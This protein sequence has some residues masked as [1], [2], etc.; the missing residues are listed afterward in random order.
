MLLVCFIWLKYSLVANQTNVTMHCL[1]YQYNIISMC[2]FDVPSLLFTRM[3][4]CLFVQRKTNEY[5][6]I[7]IYNNVRFCFC[8]YSEI[9]CLIHLE[10]IITADP[11]FILHYCVNL[12]NYHSLRNLSVTTMPIL[13]VHFRWDT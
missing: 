11:N 3:Q 7:K 8:F 1:S 9:V 13:A 10:S 12:K 2:I 6:F 5:I 4:H